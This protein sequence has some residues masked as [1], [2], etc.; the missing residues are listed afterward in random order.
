VGVAVIPELTEL[1]SYLFISGAWML[2]NTIPMLIALVRNFNSAPFC[3]Y[4]LT[5]IYNL[6]I[7]LIFIR[8]EVSIAIG[9]LFI[10]FLAIPF[11]YYMCKTSFQG[12]HVVAR[13][14]FCGNND[15]N[16]FMNALRRN[17]ALPPLI[18]VSAEAYHYETHIE[19]Y[20]TTDSKGRTQHRTRTHNVRIVTWRLTQCLNYASWEEKGNP[21]RMA[22]V[23]IL[24]CICEAY[25]FLD[26]SAQYALSRLRQDMLIEASWHDVYQSASTNFDV[27][28]L[29]ISISWYATDE[30]PCIYSFYTSVIGN[31]FWI[32]FAVCGLQTLFEVIWC[33]YG[34]RMKLRLRKAVSM[35]NKYRCRIESPDETAA[36]TTFR[37]DLLPPHSR[38]WGWW[39]SSQVSAASY[40]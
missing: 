37:I 12:N 10:I 17:R 11:D 3:T 16:A 35:E 9:A 39:N 18:S 27:P 24:H 6:G 14:S 26:E 19:H 29:N 1:Q 2:I 32:I 8:Y 21:I 13:E 7:P 33:A 30:P 38:G 20:T 5:L 31:I 4:I 28:N 34:E 40:S 25:Y 22:D 23:S 36:E 15:R